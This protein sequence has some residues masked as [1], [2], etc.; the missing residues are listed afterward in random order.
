[1]LINGGIIRDVLVG[2]SLIHVLKYIYPSCACARG[3]TIVCLLSVHLSFQPR[4]SG[5]RTRCDIFGEFSLQSLVIWVISE[6]PTC[7]LL[8]SGVF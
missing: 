5:F 6:Q 7:G 3:V 4:L 2:V 8:I 1:M